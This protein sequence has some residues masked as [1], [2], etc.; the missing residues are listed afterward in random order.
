MF[1]IYFWSKA[2]QILFSILFIA[3]MLWNVEIISVC[4]PIFKHKMFK[5]IPVFKHEAISHSQK[6]IKI[7][8]CDACLLLNTAAQNIILLVSLKNPRCGPGAR[9]S[10][11]NDS[12]STQKTIR[13]NHNLRRILL[14]RTPN[15]QLPLW[16]LTFALHMFA[17]HN[18]TLSTYKASNAHN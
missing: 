5:L 10:K 4:V 16:L 17:L 12:Y 8:S 15:Q 3:L 6:E 13:S 18:C 2:L 1:L 7:D 11:F 14:M 9:P